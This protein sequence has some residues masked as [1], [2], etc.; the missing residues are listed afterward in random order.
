ML[1]S[2]TAQVE[3]NF[4]DDIATAIFVISEFRD[5]L[6]TETARMMQAKIDKPDGFDPQRHAHLHRIR[7]AADAFLSA[8][9]GVH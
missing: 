4:D 2:T 1:E 6:H 3:T 8:L 5:L 7:I 9:S